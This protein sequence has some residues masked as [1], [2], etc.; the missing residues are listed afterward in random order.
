[1]HS[2]LFMI[3]HFLKYGKENIV[4]LGAAQII[5]LG[6]EGEDEQK[7]LDVSDVKLEEFMS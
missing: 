7:Q 2:S 3:L 4:S 1:M 5:S 6:E